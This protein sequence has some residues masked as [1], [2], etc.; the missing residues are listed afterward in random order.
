MGEFITGMNF[1]HIRST[2]GIARH[3][4][5][6]SKRLRHVVGHIHAEEKDLDKFTKMGDADEVYKDFKKLLDDYQ[7]EEEKV[8][9]IVL[10]E[11]K[12]E[13]SVRKDEQNIAVDLSKLSEKGR[14]KYSELLKKIEELQ[15]KF[16]DTFSRVRQMEK[17]VYFN[18]QRYTKY[19]SVWP[20]KFLLRQI[21]RLLRR[22]KRD[23]RHEHKD[24]DVVEKEIDKLKKLDSA[25]DSKEADKLMKEVEQSLD[26][27]IKDTDK[28]IDRFAKVMKKVN[29]LHMRLVKKIEKDVP[30]SLQTISKE[31]FPQDKLDDLAQREKNLVQLVR[32]KAHHLES[33]GWY[34]QKR[35]ARGEGKIRN[36]KN[37]GSG[38]EAA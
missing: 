19:L 28:E 31:G 5:R 37:K 34:E 29:L 20:D 4:K 18:R 25:K 38:R 30:T 17:D 32:K 13:H 9:E 8:D 27:F 6:V 22:E 23:I 7:K 24:E 21:K 10:G 33:M 14:G 1:A 26:K 35:S 2:R 12:I 15:T 36:L 11:E 3:L 16:K